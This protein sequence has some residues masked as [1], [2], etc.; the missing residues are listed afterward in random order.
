MIV[1]VFTSVDVS[2]LLL[3][4]HRWFSFVM[5]SCFPPSCSRTKT[6]CEIIHT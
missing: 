4:S 2:D 1:A 3:V 6:N 5:P